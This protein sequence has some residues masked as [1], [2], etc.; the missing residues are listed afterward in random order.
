MAGQIYQL[1]QPKSGF[2]EF[3][4]AASPYLQYAFQSYMKRKQDEQARQQSMQ[5]AQTMFPEAF[6][7]TLNPAGQAKYN[8][9]IVSPNMRQEALGQVM[10][11]IPQQYKDTQFNPETAPPGFQMKFGAGGVPEFGYTKPQPRAPSLGGVNLE[12][13]LL[14]M[15]QSEAFKRMGGGI[16]GQAAMTTKE[17]KATYEKMVK[18]LFEEYKKRF[19][20][21]GVSEETQSEEQ[22][23]QDINW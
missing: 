19:L 17:G 13:S 14:Q 11:S 6:S 9:D 15:A 20:G 7:S 18:D 12:K 10:P 16:M 8:M 1:Q 3:V 4:D 2:Q 21:G 23:A 5:Q 22:T